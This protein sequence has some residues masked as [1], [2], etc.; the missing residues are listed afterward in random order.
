M[1]DHSSAGGNNRLRGAAH[2]TLAVITVFSKRVVHRRQGRELATL[3]LLGRL[4]QLQNCS[5]RVRRPRAKNP[6]D[7][8]SPCIQRPVIPN[9]VDPGIESVAKCANQDQDC[10]ANDV[11]HDA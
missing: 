1:R 9:Y 8:I 10:T 4:R 5:N 2:L 11:G 3:R 7:G 6:Q